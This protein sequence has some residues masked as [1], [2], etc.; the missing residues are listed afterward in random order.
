MGKRSGCGVCD[1]GWERGVGKISEIRGCIQLT[2]I[3]AGL[4]TTTVSSSV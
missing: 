2:G 1:G 4:L 3:D